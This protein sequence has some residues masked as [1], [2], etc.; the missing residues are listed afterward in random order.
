MLKVLNT[1]Y[2]DPDYQLGQEKIQAIIKLLKSGGPV[3]QDEEDHPLNDVLQQTVTAFSHQDAD[4]GHGPELDIKH[5]ECLFEL[6]DKTG[7]TEKLINALVRQAIDINDLDGLKFLTTKLGSGI[8]NAPCI[9]SESGD[10]RFN[11][12]QYAFSKENVPSSIVEFFLGNQLF[13]PFLPIEHKQI[14]KDASHRKSGFLSE[15]SD[16]ILEQE[17]EIPTNGLLCAANIRA[18]EHGIFN[19]IMLLNNRDI[20]TR[21][22]MGAIDGWIKKNLFN[23]QSDTCKLESLLF[24]STYPQSV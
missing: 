24:H 8:C 22:A 14:A 2:L 10:L 17:G 12:L 11:Y 20:F 4:D 16:L 19:M 23:N 7:Q 13:D 5:T 6:K 21:L 9:D 1:E 3:F 18:D 15:S